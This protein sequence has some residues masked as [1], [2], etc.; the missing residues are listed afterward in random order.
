MLKEFAMYARFFSRL[1][2]FLTKKITPQDGRKYII[3]NL[4]DRESRFLRISQKSI[5]GNPKSPY[6][7]LLKEAGCEVGDLEQMVYSDGLEETLGKLADAG[8]RITFDEYKGRT[9][10]DRNGV[11]IQQAEYDFDNP[12]SAKDFE[13][14]TGASRSAGTRTVFDLDFISAN[15]GCHQAVLLEAIGAYSYPCGL[16]LPIM[17]SSG[18]IVAITR[19][20]IGSTPARWFT[21][22]TARDINPELKNRLGTKGLVTFARF[23]GIPIPYPEF[24][25]VDDAVVVARWIEETLGEYGG[26]TLNT[27]SSAAVRV[28]QAAEKNGLNIANLTIT[29]GGE[30]ISDAKAAEVTKAGAKLVPGYGAMDVGML[31]YGCLNP[32]HCDEVHLYTDDFAIVQRPREVPHS[33]ATVNALL[34]TSLS[35]LTPKILLNVESGDYGVVEHRSC[36]CIWEELGLDLHLHSIRAFDKL[37]SGGMTFIGTDLVR[38]IEEVLP[39]RFGGAP[40]DYQMVE[41]EDEKGLTKMSVLVNPNIGNIDERE[42]I[43]I[44]LESLSQG[45]DVHR[46]MAKMWQESGTLRVLREK[47]HTTAAGKLL[48]LHI[49]N[50]DSKTKKQII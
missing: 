20:K 39:A 42:L 27:Y 41:E 36:G 28:C 38:V 8:V 29:A 35:P 10:I 47:P 24:V 1:P 40:T 5:Y 44:I 23:C 34:I 9:S 3:N 37:T 49:K 25:S 22:I 7:P 12:A 46:M 50:S 13:S 14:R 17:P 45:T 19:A 4:A 2:G 33:R 18:P 16:W 21:P 26:C 30:P 11:T 6:L 43:H 15:W 48:P 31:G 32:V